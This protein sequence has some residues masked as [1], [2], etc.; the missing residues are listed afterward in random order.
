MIRVPT[1]IEIPVEFDDV[2]ERP[3]ARAAYDISA[4]ARESDVHLRTVAA[5][6]RPLLD[7][8]PVFAL[9]ANVN[10][11]TLGLPAD[12]RQLLSRVDGLSSVR[13]I[14][15]HSPQPI[16]EGVRGMSTLLR[17]GLVRLR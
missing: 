5:N 6:E 7:R 10:L 8:V 15:R 4:F 17:L 11:S 13:Q 1:T 16:H 12:Q 2:D 3:T 9:S 14:L